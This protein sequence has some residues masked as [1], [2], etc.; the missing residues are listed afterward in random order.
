MLN[1]DFVL[2]VCKVVFMDVGML[3]IMLW[4]EYY[5]VEVGMFLCV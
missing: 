1:L 5:G 3:I 4:R 2:L